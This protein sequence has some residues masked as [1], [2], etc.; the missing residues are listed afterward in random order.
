M[1]AR[2]VV[3]KSSSVIPSCLMATIATISAKLL[4]LATYAHAIMFSTY[5][6]NL[7]GRYTSASLYLAFAD[8]FPEAPKPPHTTDATSLLPPAPVLGLL[9]PTPLPHSADPPPHAVAH[10][11]ALDGPPLGHQ[12]GGHGPER[13]ALGRQ[14]GP[15]D[16]GFRLRTGGQPPREPDRRQRAREPP[17]HHRRVGQED[18]ALDQFRQGRARWVAQQ[19]REHV[20]RMAEAE[21]VENRVE[22]QG[23]E[24]VGCLRG[25][26]G[27]LYVE[28]EVRLRTVPNCKAG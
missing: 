5:R 15:R 9:P 16:Q 3:I 4:A 24:L 14:H 27:Q 6:S 8:T 21:A 25:G 10:L 1:P 18:G 13:H 17:R 23:A 20:A 26:H 19:R 7:I 22:G 11:F 28:R 12:P 2:H